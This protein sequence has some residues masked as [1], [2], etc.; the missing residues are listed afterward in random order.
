V[1]VGI[2]L[3]ASEELNKRSK[4][5]TGVWHMVPEEHILVQSE[6]PEFK[7]C[8]G[9]PVNALVKHHGVCPLGNNP[10]GALGFP[11]LVV[12]A[13]PG[14]IVFLVLIGAVLNNLVSGERSIISMIL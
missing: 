10:N 2:E 9:G 13:N 5:S 11:I 14:I 7:I 4:M 3:G 6:R 1:L 8:F 12:G